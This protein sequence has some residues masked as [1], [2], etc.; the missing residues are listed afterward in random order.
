MHGGGAVSLRNTI[1]HLWQRGP[2]P[3]NTKAQWTQAREKG[4]VGHQ[5]RR[6]VRTLNL[7]VT[8]IN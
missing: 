7:G 1:V 3:A 5:A 6:D 2:S 4:K 8:T